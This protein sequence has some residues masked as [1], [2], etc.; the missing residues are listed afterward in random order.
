MEIYRSILM[1]LLSG[2]EVHVTF[3][4]FKTDP[5]ELVEGTCYVIL[6]RIQ[7]I[8]KDGALNDAECFQRIEEIVEQFEALNLD[9]GARHDFG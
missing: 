6:R 8:V 3:P 9:F 5:S 1:A 7:N 4:Q 2:R